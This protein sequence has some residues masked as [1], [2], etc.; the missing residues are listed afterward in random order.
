MFYQREVGCSKVFGS[1]VQAEQVAVLQAV[2]TE[3]KPAQVFTL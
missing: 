2:F 1:S 3:R